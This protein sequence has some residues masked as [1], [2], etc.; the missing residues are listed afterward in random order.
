M[1]KQIFNP[2]LPS[3]EY[4]PDGE[5]RVFDDRLYIFGSHDKFKGKWFCEN[6]YVTWS[7]PL[8]DLSS[9]R[10]EGVIYRKDQDSRKGNLFAPDV[11]QG[12]DGKYYLYY[13]K[14]DSSVIGVAVSDKPAGKYKYLGE[15]HYKNG[16]AVGDDENEYFMF[17]PS[18]LIDGN[19]IW[20]Y[21]GSSKRK[22][23]TNIKRNMVG[24]TVME[25]EE[26]MI[27][28][29]TMPRPVLYGKNG[30]HNESFF[31]GPS[32]RKIGEL[33]Y[34]IYPVRN[35]SG[36]FYATSKFPDKGFVKRGRI[37]SPSDY[38][39]N[40]HSFWNLAYSKSNNHGGLV[41]LNGK[42]FI[43]D[44]R[45]SDNSGF[46]RQGVAEQIVIE[47]DGSIKQVEST[48]YVL[49]AKPLIAS[50]EYPSYI[51]CNIMSKKIF[52]IRNSKKVPYITQ[53]K[54]DGNTDAIS[55]ITEIKN[56]CTIGY[57]YFDFDY[58][59]GKITFF[60]R[61]KGNGRIILSVDENMKKVI[62]K[63]S[64]SSS[65]NW[66]KVDIYFK[67]NEG[68]LPL[69]FTY[70]GKEMIEFLKFKIEKTND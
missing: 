40:G 7:A 54:E 55:Y 66:A 12:L 18:I 44:H 19:R 57:K 28:V 26:D 22:T 42:W 45:N 11:I 17:D 13:S 53:D 6:D 16:K 52:W 25:L 43:F 60:Y 63:G 33:Y 4:I 9:W 50:G 29:K 47:K 35:G 48:S 38:G 69:Y 34:L 61:G 27:T 65:E 24:C 58:N 56:G 37:H 2:Y 21:S 51:A 39:I 5:P 31:E 3:Y 46:S 23:T 32:A 67:I 59:Q 62:G 15:V 1:T 14:D 36:L 41:N 30:W 10:Y 20:L 8:N 64:I 70:Q 49:N 68:I